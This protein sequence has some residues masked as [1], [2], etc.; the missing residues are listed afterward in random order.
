MKRILFVFFL[1]FIISGSICWGQKDI[2]ADYERGRSLFN[3]ICR[4][5]HLDRSQG[6]QLTAYYLR[7]RP[8]DFY[9]QDFWKRFDETKIAATV[10]SGKGAMPPQRLSAEDMQLIINYMEKKFKK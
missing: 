9:A 3:G 6:D 1:L 5:C 8:A 10:K 7:F 2:S 4:Q